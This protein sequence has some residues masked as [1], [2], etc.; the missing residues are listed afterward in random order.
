M[1]LLL[2]SS[3]RFFYRHPGQLALALIGMAA[4]VAVVTGVS[5]MRSVL[6]E[7]LDAA[8]VVLSGDD[9]VRIESISGWMDETELP[10]LAR[11][12]GSPPMLPFL[13]V[14]ARSGNLSLELLATDPISALNRG[15]A[16]SGNAVGLLS[17]PNAVLINASTAARLDIGESQSLTV[18]I[19]GQDL[20]LDVLAVVADRPA[21]DNRLLM[22]IASA[23][24]MLGR[25]G[26]LSWISAPSDARDW[27]SDR[28]GDSLRLT[29]SGQRRASAAQLTAGLRTNLTALSLLALLV[30]LF[31][32][33][34]VLSFLHVQR[35]RQIGMLR[36]IG[37]TPRLLITWLTLETLLLA[38][39]GTLAGLVA[40][41][42]L[43]GFL[44][45][46]VRAPAAELYGLIAGNT[47]TPTISLYLAISTVTLLLAAISSLGLLVA[48]LKIPPGQLSRRFVSPMNQRRRVIPALLL[49]AAG[50]IMLQSTQSL[51]PALLALFFLLCSCALL[52]PAL[53]I[54]VLNWTSRRLSFS[55][56]GR[57]L[58][59]LSASPHRLTPT[60]AALSLAFGLSAG[61]AMMVLGFRVAVDDWVTRLLRA[62]AY[63]SIAQGEFTPAQVA[64]IRQWPEIAALSSVRLRTLPDRTR[65]I[66]YELPTEAWRGFELIAGDPDSARQAFNQGLGVLIS[67]PMARRAGLELGDPV[68]I[69]TP[70]GQQVRPVAGIYRDYGSDFGVLA[71][72]AASYREWFNDNDSDS[73]GLYLNQPLPGLDELSRRLALG[74]QR[75]VLTRRDQVRDQ[76]LA[77]FDRTFRVTWALAILVGLIAVVSLVSALLALGLERRREYATLRALGLTRSGLTAW[78]LLQ[79]TGLSLIA[80]VLAVPIS[81][82][83]HV[84]LS[85]AVQPRA[86]GW[87]VPLSLDVTPWFAMLPLA[88][89]AG[90][91]AGLYPAWSIGRRD[92]APQ[93]RSA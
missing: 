12:S 5:L 93:L 16:G 75:L 45:G 41:T 91:L 86:F 73:L 24:A 88:A 50:L 31:V 54:S 15:L 39:V 38:G 72:D 66:A 89:V 46:L 22:D 30:G 44:L 36:A 55:I 70:A 49:I 80:A 13:S 58:G 84:T 62:D 21:L 1:R 77:V 2:R 81:A 69:A 19:G 35:Q 9:S 65:L 17:R 10:R 11:Q 23:Q 3:R 85:L 92:P 4:G 52:A 40:G 82:L 28:I 78:I 60:L 74:D 61:M 27:L 67:E 51:I 42:H 8:T 90:L 32:V 34:S 87:S 33:Y 6:I 18:R 14:P 57:S 25:G 26:Q 29:D 64:S 59:M 53:G 48:A 68:S 71:I 47:I 56:T 7:S 20:T 63:V 76:T 83:I 79:T 43:A 37:V